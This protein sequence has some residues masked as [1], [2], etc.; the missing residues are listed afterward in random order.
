MIRPRLRSKAGPSGL[1]LNQFK[2]RLSLQKRPHPLLI[3]FGPH[4]TGAIDQESTLRHIRRRIVQNSCLRP[5]MGSRLFDRPGQPVQRGHLR[6]ALMR[7]RAQRL[8]DRTPLLRS[9]SQ[10]YFRGCHRRLIESV[11]IDVRTCGCLAS[12]RRAGAMAVAELRP[13]RRTDEAQGGLRVHPHS[14]SSFRS[15]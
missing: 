10:N 5:R 15:S 14:M 7:G 3:L 11:P 8:R 9:A 6:S 1:L 12:S 2:L 4:R 13:T